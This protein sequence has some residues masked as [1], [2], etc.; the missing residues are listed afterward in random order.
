MFQ[1][2]RS[3]TLPKERIHDYVNSQNAP[4]FSNGEIQAALQKMSNENK[5]M[6]ADDNIFLI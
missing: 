3:D 4:A 6:V 1:E 2:N 5:I